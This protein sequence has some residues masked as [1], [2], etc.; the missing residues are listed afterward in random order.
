MIQKQAFLICPVRGHDAEE[1]AQTVAQ[2]EREGWKVHWPPR[3]TDQNDPTGYLICAR[4]KRAIK[5]ASMVFVIWDG[6]SQ[7]CLFDLG[8]AWAMGKPI[9]V[10][11][12][13]PPT[14][15]KSFQN[16]MRE[17]ETGCR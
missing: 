12:C 17:W 9:T 4:N 8:I 13:P 5:R 1:T 7:G 11:E 3:D 10:L 14:T 2:L 6:Q 15:G 16:M